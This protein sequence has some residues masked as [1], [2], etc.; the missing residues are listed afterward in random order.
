LDDLRKDS[1]LI[2]S[3]CFL[4]IGAKLGAPRLKGWVLKE[5]SS[6]AGKDFGA[7][8][9]VLGA[10][11]ASLGA[12]GLLPEGFPATLVK[13]MLSAWIFFFKLSANWLVMLAWLLNRRGAAL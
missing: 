4:V 11:E 10:E 8:A 3:F 5:S 7:K 6:V 13:A 2:S 12:P 1:S 9:E